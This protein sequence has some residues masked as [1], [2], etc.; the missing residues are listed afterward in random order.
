MSTALD[1]LFD[2]FKILIPAAAVVVAVQIIM[3]N[4]FDELTRRDR[5]ALAKEQR[6]DLRPLQ[7]QAYERLILFLERLKPD[8]L[9][10]RNQK[11]GMSSRALHTSMLKTIRNEYEHNMTQQLYVSESA[12]KLVVIARDEIV[13]IINLSAAQVDENGSAIDLGNALISTLSKIENVPTEIAIL[14]LKKEFQNKF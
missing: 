13:K 4:H 12:W 6:K 11:A 8:S 7:M 9:M 5:L 1:Y 14:G 10:V 2:L 3:K